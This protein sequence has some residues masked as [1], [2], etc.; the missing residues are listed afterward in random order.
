METTDPI[1]AINVAS[2][3]SQI[4]DQWNP[5]VVAELNGQH[6]RL[7]KIQGDEFEPHVHEDEDEMFLVVRGE[8]EIEF[9]DGRVPVKQGEF[10]VVPKGVVHRPVTK[11]EAE[12]MM[13]VTNKNVNTGNVEND[14]T[15]NTN[16]LDRL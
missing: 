11:D 15:L 6:I 1:Q 5:R 12:L 7:V 8:I 4:T 14:F 16:T 10:I 3:L 13:F 2:K 9:E